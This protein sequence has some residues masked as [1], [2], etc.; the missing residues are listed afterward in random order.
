M[1]DS[2]CKEATEYI[3]GTS[4]Q[5]RGFRSVVLCQQASS[6]QNAFILAVSRLPLWLPDVSHLAHLA[7]SFASF[8]HSFEYD[9]G[10]ILL[11]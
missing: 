9:T 7:T 11:A 5:L 2:A 6:F 8:R 4:G 3:G 1:F 10:D